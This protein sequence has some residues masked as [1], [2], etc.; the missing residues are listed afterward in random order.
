MFTSK[1]SCSINPNCLYKNGEPFSSNVNCKD[2]DFS[3]KYCIKELSIFGLEC[4]NI[5]FRELCILRGCYWENDSCFESSLDAWFKEISNNQNFDCKAKGISCFADQEG[6]ISTIDTNSVL[7]FKINNDFDYHINSFT[8]HEFLLD[9]NIVDYKEIE[10]IHSYKP[11]LL[12]SL[13]IRFNDI[14]KIFGE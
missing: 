6:T 10:S 9:V 7:S 11:S 4:S 14:S 3:E 1:F 8:I 12:T 2:S 13:T 5:I